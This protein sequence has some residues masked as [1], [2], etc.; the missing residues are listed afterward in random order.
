MYQV[1]F[2]Y[3]FGPALGP[4]LARK[5]RLAPARWRINGDKL[6]SP[7]PQKCKNPAI[8]SHIVGF[9]IVRCHCLQIFQR[10]LLLSAPV[11]C[12]H[13]SITEPVLLM[14]LG[15]IL[16]IFQYQALVSFSSQE[17]VPRLKT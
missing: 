8:F 13:H 5:P 14:W 4:F 3:F 6:H 10:I 16:F 12:T 2:Q 17:T 1:M 15:L 7:L 11:I 9:S